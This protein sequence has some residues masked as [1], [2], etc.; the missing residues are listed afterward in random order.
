MKEITLNDIITFNENEWHAEYSSGF[1][2]YKHNHYGEWIYEEDYNKLRDLNIQYEKDYK[3]IAEFRS[4][5]L[6]FGEYPEYVIQE[7]LKNKYEKIL[8]I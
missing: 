6:P 1:I 5:C 7:F 8:K 3:L 4:E 2:G